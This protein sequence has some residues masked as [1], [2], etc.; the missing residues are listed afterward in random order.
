MIKIKVDETDYS[1]KPLTVEL[2]MECMKWDPKEGVNW[3]KIISIVTGAPLEDVRL[4][5]MNE[6]HIVVTM[7]VL[8]WQERKPVKM[9]LPNGITFGEFIDLEVHLHHGLEHSLPRVLE[10]LGVETQLSSEGLWAAE[11]YV[12]F[13][14]NI[15]KQYAG[16]FGLSD[17]A[18]WE[19]PEDPQTP[20]TKEVI[21]RGWYSVLL[22]LS[23]WNLLQIDQI[24]EEPLKKV[25]NFM[26][27]KK[28]RALEEREQQLKKQRQNELQRNRR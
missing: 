23:D 13:R 22:E 17:P 11:K 20:P 21:A 5:S 2:W 9:T 7:I 14:D 12:E 25:L 1:I 19:D 6:Q 28:Q 24:V 8:N 3:A 27:A 15:Y 16:L 18:D 10:I 4:A 26:A